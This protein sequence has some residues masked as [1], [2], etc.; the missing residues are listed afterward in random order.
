VCIS[1]NNK[2]DFATAGSC[3]AADFPVQGL[4]P[5]ALMFLFMLPISVIPYREVR[6]IFYERL[7]HGIF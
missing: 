3:A 2:K 4:H 1:W 5:L 7:F 6:E